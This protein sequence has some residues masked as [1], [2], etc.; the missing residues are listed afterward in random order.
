MTNDRTL[1]VLHVTECYAGG[2]KTA[3]EGYAALDLPVEHHIIQSARRHPDKLTSPNP[4]LFNTIS[5]LPYGH[6]AAVKAT[7]KAIREVQPDVVHAH[8]SF[9]GV[10]GRL[11]AKLTRTPVVYTP[12]GLSF[13]RRDISKKK[14]FVF[15]QIERAFSW[16]STVQAGCASYETGL[17]KSLNSRSIVEVVPNA[18]AN[19]GLASN[20]QVS[21]EPADIQRSISFIG[22][23]VEARHPEMAIDI[24]RIATKKGF[25]CQWIGDGDA[26]MKQSLE[27]SGIHVTGWLT[28]A[29]MAEALENISFVI[30]TARWDGFPMVILEMLNARKLLLVEDIPALYECPREARFESA[31]EAVKKLELLLEGGLEPD[32]SPITN[33]YNQGTQADRLLHCYQVAAGI[34]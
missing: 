10:Y 26:A 17:L 13:E 23:I 32:W 9:G 20:S 21:S 8:S 19:S 11:A 27:D 12:H 30:H 34:E 1:K 33:L 2:V 6:V 31:E 7:I 15:K 4:D 18:I 16:L 29:E 25:T 24:A 28:K 22:R 5:E 14:R 3:L